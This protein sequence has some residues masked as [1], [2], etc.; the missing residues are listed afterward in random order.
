MQSVA[1][2]RDN[3]LAFR[4]FERLETCIRTDPIPDKKMTKS[5][6]VRDYEY[7]FKIVLIGD[8]GVGKSSLLLRFADDAFI[9]SYM[10][11]IGV[12]FR[13]KTIKTEK[14]TVKLQIWDT[15]GQEKFRY[16]LCHSFH[17]YA[18]HIVPLIHHYD[19]L[20]GLLRLH[21]IEAQTE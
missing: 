8:S 2:I 3:L 5:N 20:P 6:N 12:D 9:E 13:F 10:S 15:A 17:I 14:K 7:L 1:V 11:T 21:I 4:L 19:N 16:C 18:S